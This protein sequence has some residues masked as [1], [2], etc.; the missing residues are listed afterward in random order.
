MTFSSQILN[1]SQHGVVQNGPPITDD[2]KVTFGEPEINEAT[3]LLSKL[4]RR[5]LYH[6]IHGE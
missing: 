1:T 5:E 3:E 6:K 2:H 4:H